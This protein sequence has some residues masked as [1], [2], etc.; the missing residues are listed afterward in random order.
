MSESAQTIDFEGS[1]AE[2]EALVA[3]MEGDSLSLEESLA[4]FE[5]GVQLTR[6][7]QTALRT[8]EL[9]IKALTQDGTEAQLP[10][11]GDDDMPQGR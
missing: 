8:A 5:R 11:A 10:P 2:L 7:C 3:K 4:A 6:A 1:L 9:R